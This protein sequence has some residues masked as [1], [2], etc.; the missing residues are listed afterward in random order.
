MLVLVAAVALVL[1]VAVVL[2]SMFRD[3]LS[4]VSASSDR[5]RL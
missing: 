4:L 5:L 2:I 3:L 1:P